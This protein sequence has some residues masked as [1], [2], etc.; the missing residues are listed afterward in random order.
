M[1]EIFEVVIKIFFPKVVIKI[2]L[3][4]DNKYFAPVPVTHLT[5]A[6]AAVSLLQMKT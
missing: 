4:N 1:D 2:F 6:F 5:K 3:K